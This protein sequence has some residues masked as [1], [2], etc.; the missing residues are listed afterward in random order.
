MNQTRRCKHGTST[1]TTGNVPLSSIR[2]GRNSL[3][4]N[5][6]AREIQVQKM[7]SQIWSTF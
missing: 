6:K 2:C 7:Q 3:S 5:S 4:L 1:D